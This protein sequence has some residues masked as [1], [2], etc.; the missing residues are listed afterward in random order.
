MKKTD[1][2]SF[3]KRYELLSST[4]DYVASVI[5]PKVCRFCKKIEPSTSFNMKAHVIS[6]LL[7]SNNV[8]ANDECDN[9]NKIFS[10]YESHLSL[11]F[12]PYLTMTGTSGK[13][14]VPDFQSRTVDR[15]ENTR[16]LIKSEE[17]RRKVILTDSP[18]Y[19][20]DRENKRF[21]LIF[22]KPPLIPFLVYK[23]LVKIGLSLIPESHLT[24]FG[25]VFNWLL[26]DNHWVS[27]F[28]L[29]WVNL[30]TFKKFS[31][32]Y[33]DL[34]RAKR[35]LYSKSFSAEYTLVVGFANVIVQIFLPI[36][37]SLSPKVAGKSPVLELF[38]GFAFDDLS[39]KDVVTISGLDLSERETV[40]LNHRLN[41]T[42]QNGEF[43]DNSGMQSNTGVS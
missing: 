14:G 7:G 36:S 38:P 22:R 31:E 20:L 11:Y 16:T 24:E 13:R 25:E 42:F 6:E 29:C 26:N 27:T 41:F 1:P 5:S 10:A 23:A 34:Y 17:N 12:R 18:D 3:W 40:T 35:V 39:R 37:D 8:I 33:A 19:E 28:Q 9:C 4:K 32:P 43:R 30:L 2:T 21:T 15:N